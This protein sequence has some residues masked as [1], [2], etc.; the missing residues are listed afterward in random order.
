MVWQRKVVWAEGMFLRPQHFQQQERYV[1]FLVQGRTLPAQPFYWGFS[2]LT[3]DTQMLALGKI[4]LVSAKG[5]LPDGTPFQ[6]PQGDEAP[7]P[8]DVGKDIKDALI[9]L[10]L[11]LRRRSGAEVTLSD[12]DT[13]MTRYQAQVLEVADT[14]DVGA[15]PAEVQLG[16]ARFSL[17]ASQ[18]LS[19][20]WVSL[21][22]AHVVE[23]KA[24][25]A[26]LL[27]KSFI[28]TVVNNSEV[29]ALFEFCR[30]LHGLRR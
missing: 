26:A 24:D 16:I 18:D 10:S 27:D 4:A 22:V 19:E 17:R 15:Q 6:I 2:E 23:R 3:L 5:V 13:G 25:G 1:D 9:H 12:S 7:S 30:E 14:N 29:S 11:P 20:G 8:L 21:P 28:P